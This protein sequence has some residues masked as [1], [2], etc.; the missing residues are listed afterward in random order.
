MKRWLS[1]LGATFTPGKGSHL[2]VDWNGNKSILPM[3][4]KEHQKGHRTR[5]QEKTRPQIRE[6]SM[7]AY[8]VV[9]TPDKEAGGFVVTFPDIRVL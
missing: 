2:R 5:Y 4:H 6:K 8:P 9:L 7:L 3:Q 1:S